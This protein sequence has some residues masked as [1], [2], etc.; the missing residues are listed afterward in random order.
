M[1][2][3]IMYLYHLKRDFCRGWP[4]EMLLQI[5]FAPLPRRGRRKLVQE[6]LDLAHPLEKP[7]SK[8]KILF[9]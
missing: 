3:R 4:C 5:I 9:P 2:D 8:N 7:L 1:E 6:F